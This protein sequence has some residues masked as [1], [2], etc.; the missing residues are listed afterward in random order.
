MNLPVLFLVFKFPGKLI[1]YELILFDLGPKNFTGFSKEPSLLNQLFDKNTSGVLDVIIILIRTC[2]C[3]GSAT[4][5]HSCSDV[6]LILSSG[7]SFWDEFWGILPHMC[8]PLG[9]PSQSSDF[10]GM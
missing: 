8:A 7:D 5:S 1:F 9:C 6:I 2:R 10:I 3:C 4:Q